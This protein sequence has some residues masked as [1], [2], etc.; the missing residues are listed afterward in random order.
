MRIKTQKTSFMSIINVLKKNYRIIALVV[1]TALVPLV[2]LLVY[3]TGG[4]KYVFSHTMYIP[5]LLAGMFFGAPFGLLV[6]LAG[7][8]LLGPL[9]PFETT[10][11]SPEPQEFIN[12]FYRMIIFMSMGGISGYVSNKLRRD[13]QRINELMSHNQETM[14][15]NTNYLGAGILKLSLGKQSLITVLIN[16][17]NS[18]TDVLGTEVFHKL[19]FG[20]YQDLMDYVGTEGFVVQSG[21]NKLW[22]VKKHEDLNIEAGQIWSLLNRPRDIDN[23]PMYVDYAVGLNSSHNVNNCAKLENFRGS[24]TSARLAQ[25]Q[26]VPYIIFDESLTQKRKEYELLA[27]FSR[28]LEMNQ[29]FLV[30][31]PKIDLKTGFPV[32]LEALIRWEHA[33]RGILYPDTFIPIVEQTKLIHPMTDWVLRRA[34]KKIWEFSGMGM[35]FPISINISARN[36]YDTDFFDRAM[37]IIDESQLPKNLIEMEITESVLM[38]D[39]EVSKNSLQKFV[40]NGIRIAIDDFGKGYSSLAYLSQFPIDVIKIDKFFMRQIIQNVSS[41]QIVSATIKLAKQ[42]GYKVVAEGVE[43]EEVAKLMQEYECDYAQGYLYAKP[44]NDQDVISW[45]QKHCRQKTS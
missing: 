10:V 45:Y 37:K 21:R 14:I 20:I 36:L 11:I 19:I 16:N 35:T 27:T 4:I 44:M 13:A 23:I 9:M 43:E 17:H 29:T 6:G 12:W 15:P 26:N 25:N 34:L 8:I 2:Y 40:A 7:G 1:V 33:E 39:P 24:D 31:Q 30:Y 22:V 41:Q 42:L 3:A 32:G 5:I 18:I 28:A 38:I